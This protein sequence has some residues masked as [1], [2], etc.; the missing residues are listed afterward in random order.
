MELKC[1]PVYLS[2]NLK[3]DWE[4]AKKTVALLASIE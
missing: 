2:N 3:L 4:K 1:L